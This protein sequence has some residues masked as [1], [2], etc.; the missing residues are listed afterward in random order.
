MSTIY[1]VARL[2]GVSKTTVSKILGGSK[3]VRP[4][5]L[6]R[7]NAAMK[8][9]D[10]VPN[11]FAQGMRGSGTK[12]IAVLLPEQYN[13]GYMEILAGIEQCANKNGYL[14]FVCSTGREGEHEAKYLKEAVRRKVDAI[15]Y[16]TYRR[17]EKNLAYLQ[18]IAGEIAVVVMDNVLAGEAL[19]EVRVDGNALTKKA[20]CY[21]AGKGCE[22]I[23]YI[24]GLDAYD[25]TAER[26]RG[27]VEGLALC[28][29]GVDDA[30]VARTEFTMEGG[31][32]AARAL[33]AKKPDAILT[34]TD[35]LALGALDYMEAAGV[36]VPEEVCI[37]GFD[38]IPLCMWSRPRLSTLSQN[39]RKIGEAAVQ[40][41]LAR[42]A[43]PGQ[44]AVRM[45]L[46][47]ELI[48]RETT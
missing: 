26:Y 27:Y 35:M 8:E 7:V 32:D 39:Q 24:R 15:L 17:N 23:A 28:G 1:D 14:T 34:A 47:G 40:R 44:E 10:Y 4:A 45:L 43:D 18:R 21:L 48:L 41:A 2:A 20:V 19:D 3:N 46:D 16:F 37:I 31:H 30:L 29:I 13:Y 9:L 11:C 6:E 33:M 42:I 5:T 22:R 36:R 25:A 38:N 12:T